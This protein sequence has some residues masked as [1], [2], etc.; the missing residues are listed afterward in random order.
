[1]TTAEIE[2]RRR[3]L[4]RA[5]ELLARERLQA[6]ESGSRG[7]RRRLR[8]LTYRL[9]CQFLSHY[10]S[11]PPRWRRLIRRFG[12]R[13][14]LPDFCVIGPAKAATSDLAVTLMLHPNVVT[15]LVKELWD[16]D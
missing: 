14:V 11:P 12:G 10:F 4:S 8:H 3:R 16:T 9:Q 2:K 5:Y 6:H 7:F 1:M 13:R 15:P